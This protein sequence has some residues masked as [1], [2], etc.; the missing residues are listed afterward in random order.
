MGSYMSPLV[1]FTC[2]CDSFV[3]WDLIDFGRFPSFFF[4]TLVSFSRLTF[5]PF[6]FVSLS[7]ARSLRAHSSA[8][9]LVIVQQ[10]YQYLFYCS[11]LSRPPLPTPSLLPPPHSSL[12]LVPFAPPQRRSHNSSQF[13]YSIPF[14]KLRLI[15]MLYS[16]LC[17]SYSSKDFLFLLRLLALL[18]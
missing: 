6:L 12:S 15:L 14:Y 3:I 17:S 7:P 18:S 1:R 10:I 8:D 2:S 4:F 11:P 5:L 9:S 13:S 16:F